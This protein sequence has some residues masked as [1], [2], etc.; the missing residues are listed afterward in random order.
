MTPSQL[1]NAIAKKF[2]VIPPLL[3]SGDAE[4]VKLEL[5]PYLQ[6]FEEELAKRELAALLAPNEAISEKFGLVIV[7][8]DRPEEYFHQRLTY[9]QRAGRAVLTPT[10]QIL[11]ELTQNGVEETTARRELHRS[12]RLRYG[13]H[14]LHEYRGKFFPQLVR[15]LITIADT[16][17]Q[18]IVLDPMCGSGTTPCEVIASGR[19]ALGADLNP[20]SVLISSVKAGVVLEPPGSFQ[21]KT[22]TYLERV[23]RPAKASPSEV[24]PDDLAYLERWFDQTALHETAEIVAAIDSISDGLYRSLFKVCLSNCVRSIS[25]QKETDLRVRKEV[26]PYEPGSASSLFGQAVLEQ[27][28]RIY[29]YLSVLH[30]PKTQQ[31]LLIQ[32]GDSVHVD[33]LFP[34]YKERVDLILTSPPYATAL[35]Y[36]DTDRLSLIALRLLPRKNHK[37]VEA[38]MVGTREVTDR[39]RRSAWAAY[40]TR[41]AEL[42]TTVSDLID[43]IAEANHKEGVGFRRRNLPALLGKYFLS[44]LDAMRSARTLIKPSGHAFYVVGNNSTFVE[45]QKIEIPTDTFLFEIGALAGWRQSEMI[46]MELLP[47]RDIF[48]ENRGSKE[49][50]LCFKA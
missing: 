15:S 29:G 20:L 28:D 35:P 17:E 10:L 46:P 11:L 36:I 2:S 37:T 38:H 18:G 21:Q 8:T 25:W 3:L 50:I 5:K 43:S 45:D 4:A 27:K 6:P 16:P 13:P 48:K 39:E 14:D 33:R 1:S 30:H 19:S 44:M 24:W 42:P 26:R 34:E 31:Q 32:K 7:Q 12:R 22:A 49:T 40:L 9:W 47:S 41:K 23:L